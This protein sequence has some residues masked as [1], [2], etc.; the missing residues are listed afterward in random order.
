MSQKNKKLDRFKPSSSNFEFLD[1]PFYWVVRL[2]AKYTHV[3]EVE[4]KKVNMNISGWRVAII[5]REHGELSISDIATHAVGKLSTIAK[6]VYRMRDE[7]L[8]TVSPL[9]SD[10]RVAMVSIT[11]K[12][13]SVI[14]SVTAQTENLFND[15]FDGFTEVQIEKLNLHLQ[16]LFN[17]L[18]S[19]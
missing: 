8:L 9:S 2:N 10:G 16:K 7:G 3:M 18:H 14:E 1:F 11:E 4:L 5:L 6:I 19:H 12:G 17:N 15:A 13:S